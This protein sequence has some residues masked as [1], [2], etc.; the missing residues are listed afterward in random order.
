MWIKL[1][2]A[3][4]LKAVC[5]ESISQR[6]RELLAVVSK[7][8]E[9]QSGGVV[10]DSWRERKGHQEIFAKTVVQL[11]GDLLTIFLPGAVTDPTLEELRLR[12]FRKVHA[13]LAPLERLG[14]TIRA[15]RAAAWPFI[16]IG[17]LWGL[18]VVFSKGPGGLLMFRF[19]VGPI[20]STIAGLVSLTVRR[21]FLALIKWRASLL[22]TEC[23]REAEKRAEQKLRGISL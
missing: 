10:V 6:S 23:R 20:V 7:I 4:V 2:I 3:G 8:S 17:L 9:L 19:V 5:P 21:V 18:V 15:A 13:A 1:K 22:L 16:V 14:T 11:D 12:H